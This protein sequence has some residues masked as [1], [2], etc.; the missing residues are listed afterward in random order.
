MKE[1]KVL[2]EDNNEVKKQVNK[3]FSE[4]WY[5]YLGIFPHH[6]GSGSQYLETNLNIDTVKSK[7]HYECSICNQKIYYTLESKRIIRFISQ[8]KSL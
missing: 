1:K 6:C 5:L 3:F 7:I 2:V 8:V 4:G